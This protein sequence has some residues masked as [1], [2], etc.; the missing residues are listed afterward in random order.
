MTISTTADVISAA[1]LERRR[2]AAQAAQAQARARAQAGQAQVETERQAQEAISETE[3]Q[4][5]AAR[6][7]AQQEAETRQAQIRKQRGT[8][9]R[10]AQAAMAKARRAQA[11]ESRKVVLPF[12]KPRDLGTVSYI[13]SVEAARKQAHKT[14]EDA[15]VAVTKV[16]DD[17]FK[18]VDK[19]R[20]NAVADI[21]KQKAGIVTD[22]QTQ[23]ANY[24][25]DITKQIAQLNSG[26]DGWEAESKTAIQK[27]QADY[28]AAVKA[29]LNRD[30]TDVFADMK[31]KGLIPA[32]AVYD[33]YD[34]TTGQ[35]NY[36]TPDIRSGQEIFADLQSQNEIPPTAT[37]ESYDSNTGEVNYN[38]QIPNFGSSIFK[39]MQTKGEI[40]KDATFISYNSKDRTVTYFVAGAGTTTIPETT[41]ATPAP[42]NSVTTSTSSSTV[43]SQGST[44]VVAGVLTASATVMTLTKVGAGVVTVPT[45]PTWAIG[46]ILLATAIIIGVIERHRIAAGIKNI[47]DSVK[48]ETSEGKSATQ[49]SD[50]VITNDDGSV[51]LTIQQFTATPQT[52]K[53]TIEGIPLAQQK[54]GD[55]KDYFPEIKPLETKTILEQER[56][57]PEGVEKI[58]GPPTVIIR[59]P[60]DVPEL[61]VKASNILIAATAVQTAANSIQTATKTIPMTREQWSRIEEALRQGKVTEGKK[62]IESLAK[63]AGTPEIA[64]NLTEAYREYLR[65]KAI[66]DAA[67]KAYV[68]SLNPQ[69]IKGRGSTAAMAAAI[70]VWLTQ[71]IIQGEI[72][73]ALNRGESMESAMAK[74]QAKIR[75]VSEQL[76]LTQQQINAATAT[77]VYQAALSSMTQEAIKAASQAQTEGLTATQ[78]KTQTLTATKAAA[79]TA[80]QNAVATQSLTQT[81][82]RALENE[83]TRVAEQVAE[84]TTKLKLP[85]LPKGE[86][87]KLEKDRYPDGTIVWRMGKTDG[88]VYKIIPPPYTM[89]KPIT[90]KHP[91][92]GMTKTKGTPQET[93]T[94]IG[95]KLPFKNVSFDLGVTDGFIDVKSRTI[96]F[97]G[98]GQETN[99]GTRIESTTKGVAL[100]DNP[101]LLE[102]LTKRGNGRRVRGRTP[103]TPVESL[104]RTV[105]SRKPQR[106]VSHGVYSDRQDTRITR[107]RYRGWKR[108]Y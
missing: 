95:G 56:F 70:G 26:I 29:A 58:K 27:A 40:P 60:F 86:A 97:T 25:A 7:Q 35:L 67:R 61:R 15:K 64:R 88:D 107:R 17:Y 23:L 47:I 71:D 77:V 108:I 20:D 91:P 102:Q 98:R 82:A 11:I 55:I 46:G 14:G 4:A 51:A 5:Q 33:S 37:Y 63:K 9:E 96:K 49:A 42:D 3:R 57:Q 80:V 99:V 62:I 2:L 24:N 12:T 1:E 84:L 44:N 81:Q 36:T 83:L 66:L 21:Q 45:P 69:P 106:L 6:T 16:R 38:V 39:R 76:G 79:R 72:L 85:E 92:K 19:A 48:G 28:E 31:D 104:V 34:K 103:K 90:S 13:A 10:E 93:L 50:A 8:A 59:D 78:I 18:Q 94:F 32:N 101:P 41:G 53:G 22:I 75:E 52:K 54:A 43:Q 65:K 68:A 73:K 74:A 89:L 87:A 105:P 100:T 30:G